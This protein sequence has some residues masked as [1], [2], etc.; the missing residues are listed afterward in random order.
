MKK[1]FFTLM[2]V[3]FSLNASFAYQLTNEELLQ[4]ISIQHVIDNI[5]YN[6]LNT[7][8]IKNKMMFTYDKEGKKKLLKCNDALTKR[9]IIIYGDA[10][11][12]VADKNELAAM[13]AREIVKAD[14]SYWG[15]FKGFIGAT[16]IRCAPKKYELYFDRAAVDLMVKAGYNPIGMIT[17]LYKVYPQKRTDFIAASNL[18]SKR[19]M[20]VYEYIYKTY[21]EFLVNNEYRNNPVY[22]NFLLTSTEN[23][24]KFYEKIKNKSD[25][26]IKYE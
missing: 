13:I 25:E 3:M 1:I 2:A 15:Y 11:Q 23:R 20:Y 21:P 12:K 22:Q 19:V 7:A 26:K 14:A 4:N 18:T 5:G 17:F 16:Q 6:L 8:Q 24:V 10:V 9:E